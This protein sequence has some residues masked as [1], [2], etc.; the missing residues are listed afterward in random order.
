LRNE[1]ADA[2]TFGDYQPLQVS[3]PHRDHVIAFARRHG[4]DA[5]IVAVAKSFAAF[6]QGGRAWPHADAFDGTIDINGYG[7]EGAS[8]L[9]LAELF[10]QLPVAVRKATFAGAAR[11]TRKRHRA[12]S[13]GSD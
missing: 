6:T 9:R 7:I 4:R 11:T 8:E 12:W 3:G 2:F 1:L 10:Q 13:I 5:V